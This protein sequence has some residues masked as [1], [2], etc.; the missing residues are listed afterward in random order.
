MA[1]IIAVAN[2]KGGVGKTTTSVNLSASLAI[3][4]NRVLLVDCD[5]QANSTSSLGFDQQNLPRNLYTALC[6]T[7]T[8]EETLLPTATPYLS[9][10]PSSVKHSTQEYGKDLAVW[11]V[12]SIVL[13]LSPTLVRD[14]L[15]NTRPTQWASR[16]GR[17][18][19]FDL[20]WQN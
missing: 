12:L 1:R 6:G 11:C 19:L 7:S 3:M 10:L 14:R 20:D 15:R 8:L 5:P 16:R 18:V 9:L 17:S 13:L 2:Q 4:E